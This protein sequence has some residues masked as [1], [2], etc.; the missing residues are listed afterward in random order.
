MI[1][2]RINRGHLIAYFLSLE[3][4]YLIAQLVLERV[5]VNAIINDIR[6]AICLKSRVD[7][8]YTTEQVVT[9]QLLKNRSTVEY[10][11]IKCGSNVL[12]LQ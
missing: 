5:N 4:K 6:E 12:E 10:L 8:L 1:V 3:L 2:Y 9:F 11:A 7:M